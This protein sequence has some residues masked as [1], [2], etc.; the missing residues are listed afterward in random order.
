MKLTLILAI[1][2][3]VLTLNCQSTNFCPSYGKRPPIADGCGECLND[4]E[5]VF[6]KCMLGRL[7]KYQCQD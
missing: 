5:G 1:I 3:A 7:H 6:L 2:I 4:E